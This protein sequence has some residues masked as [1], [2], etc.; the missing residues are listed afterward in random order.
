MLVNVRSSQ[1][2]LSQY[3]YDRFRFT[4]SHTQQNIRAT[5]TNNQPLLFTRSLAHKCHVSHGEFQEKGGDLD[6][7]VIEASGHVGRSKLEVAPDGDFIALG[8]CSHSPGFGAGVSMDLG[9]VSEDGTPTN[10]V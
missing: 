4:T 9:V 3:G 5:L 2:R 1:G 7:G 6:V 8:V 10:A